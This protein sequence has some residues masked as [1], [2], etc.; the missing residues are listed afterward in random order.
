M[1]TLQAAT[2][3]PSGNS[4][5]IDAYRTGCS[6]QNSSDNGR[7]RGV[8]NPP[9]TAKFGEEESDSDS[10]A[11]I[12]PGINKMKVE[13]RKAR[14]LSRIQKYVEYISNS[15]FHSNEIMQGGNIEASE[16]TLVIEDPAVQDGDLRMLSM[17][18]QDSPMY[19][20]IFEYIFNPREELKKKRSA[21][22]VEENETNFTRLIY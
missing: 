15:V 21:E 2:R 9:G 14:D 6:S 3:P 16:A 18:D 20:V 13:D 10:L 7:L 8:V 17:L 5:R 12:P 4:V 22:T 1:L 19:R 11:K